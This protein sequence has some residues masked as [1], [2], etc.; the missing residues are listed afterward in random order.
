MQII[1][2][3]IWIDILPSTSVISM[4]IISYHEKVRRKRLSLDLQPNQNIELWH[5]VHVSY[6]GSDL[7]LEEE[8]LRRK[9]HQN[10][11]VIISLPSS[12]PQTQC[13]MRKQN[14]LRWIFTLFGRKIGSTSFVTRL[15]LPRCRWWISSPDRLGLIFSE[16]LLQNNSSLLCLFLIVDSEFL[17]QTNWV[18]SFLIY[19]CHTGLD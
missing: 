7:S 12:L 4:V 5:R 18:F 16:L 14:T 2:G 10:Y 6:Y 13:F 15:S 8:D 3:P 1:L 19:H 17:Y 11:I 9:S